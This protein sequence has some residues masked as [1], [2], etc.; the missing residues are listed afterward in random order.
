MV[1]CRCCHGKVTFS[2]GDDFHFI[3][4]E[5]YR[6]TFSTF[7]GHASGSTIQEAVA[8]RRDIDLDLP[9]GFVFVEKQVPVQPLLH[10]MAHSDWRTISSA[11]SAS[12][13]NQKGMSQN[14]LAG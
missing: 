2:H 3:A 6:L 11:S 13:Q 12:F 4:S 10:D 1:K 8:W 7:A 9:G 5:L 14:T